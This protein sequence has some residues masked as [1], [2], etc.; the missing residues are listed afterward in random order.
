MRILVVSNRLPVTVIERKGSLSYKDSVGGLVS[1]LRPYLA[2]LTDSSPPRGEY[3]WIGWPGIVAKGDIKEELREKLSS[4]FR[5]HPVFLNK[6]TVEKFYRGFCNRTI[7]PLFHYFPTYA[8]FDEEHWRAY[9]EVNEA[10]CDSVME[11]I[12]PDDLLWIHDYHLML[13]PKLVR[14]EMPNVAIGYFHHIPFPSFEIFRL[15]PRRWGR[16]IL[17]G[18]LGSD[19]V[20]FHTNDYTQYFLR[21]V[22]RVLGLEHERGQLIVNDRLVKADTLP[23]GVDFQRFQNASTAPEVVKEQEKLRKTLKGLKLI[24]SVDRLDYTKGILNRL[25]GYAAFLAKNPKWHKRVVLLLVVVPSR[26]GVERYREMK[27]QIDELVGRINGR[28]GDVE[29]TPVLYQYSH[30]PLHTLVA[31]YLISDV[32]LITPLRDGMNLIAKEYIATKTDRTGVLI[33]SEMAGASR[34]LGEAILI[35]PNDKEEMADAL[36]EG[37]EMA[38]QVQV[39]RNT[40]MFER[41]RRHDALHWG[42]DFVKELLSAKE[43]QGSLQAKILSSEAEDH[44]VQSYNRSGR[45]LIFVDY[46]GTLIPFSPDSQE[47]RPGN[48]ILEALKNLSQERGTEVV[49]TSG[50]IKDLLEEWFGVL[51]VGLVA[52]HGAFVKEGGKEWRLIKSLRGEWKSEIL[53][54]LEMY[55]DRLPGS[56]VEEKEF[57]L[58]WHYRA[59][60]PEV[61]GMRARELADDLAGLKAHTD[62]QV[63]QGSKVIEVRNAG[64]DKGT[65][66]LEWLSKGDYDFVLAIGDDWSDEDLFA[67]LP[68]SAWSIRVGVA[69]SY[70]R[71]SVPNHRRVS[72]LLGKLAVA[73]K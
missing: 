45:R 40:A 44:L 36:R 16:D 64:V 54:M 67:V 14:E 21:S 8:V 26:T 3:T 7:W 17:E 59:A 28:F 43:F 55:S 61:G 66:A 1:G 56:F 57:S 35:N 38:P 34:E 37:L 51:S 68:D 70:A 30:L 29:W 73:R 19:L 22:L 65:A 33:L 72:D 4:E 18:L 71:F 50:R 10:F 62:V 25:Q 27:E 49:V 31:M 20:G 69:D 39:R 58:V 23:L 41:L 6:E 46:D 53:P 63:L 24:L 9:G 32:A 12:R 60:D 48:H 13:L 42:S 5:A 47:A 15:L 2:S 52:E 11:I